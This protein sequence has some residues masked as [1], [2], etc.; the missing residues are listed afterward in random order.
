[1]QWESFP[2]EVLDTSDVEMLKAELLPTS[3][4]YDQYQLV[5]GKTPPF[6]K[7]ESLDVLANG[8]MNYTLKGI[9]AKVSV[10]WAFQAPEGTAD[11]HYSIMRGTKANLIIRQGEEEKYKPVLY[12]KLLDG[13]EEELKNSI[14]TALQENYPGISLSKLSNGEFKIE[15]PDSYSVGHE[16]HFAQVTENYLKFFKQGEMPDWEVPNMIVKYYTTTLAFEK[17]Q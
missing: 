15:V 5:T 12:V 17:A 16:A 13:Q 10:K 6:E 14:N 7:G 3:L 4:G 1:V 11:T 2:G 8:E 9:H